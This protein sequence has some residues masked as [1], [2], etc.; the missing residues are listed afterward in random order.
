[1]SRGM[2]AARPTGGEL[3][4]LP[5]VVGVD[6]SDSARHAAEWAAEV[7]SAWRA[8]VRL[9][10]ADHGRTEERTSDPAWL[11]ELLDAVERVGVDEVESRVVPGPAVDELMTSSHDA[12]L[13][14]RGRRH[15]PARAARAGGRGPRRRRRPPP[16]LRRSTSGF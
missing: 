16:W 5:I 7:A 4:R 1:M 11:R 13:V 2:S 3:S 6:G 10:H 12:G 14:V 8:P 15:R 9:V